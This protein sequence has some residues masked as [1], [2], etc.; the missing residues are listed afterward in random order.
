MAELLTVLVVD[1]EPDVCWALETLLRGHRFTV[2]TASSGADALRWLKVSEPICHLI[3]V[4]AK[5]SDI[6]GVDLAKRIRTETSC[7]APM[8]LVSGYFYKDDILVQDTLRTGLV[9][10]FVTKP[11]RHDEMLNAINAVLSTG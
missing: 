6:D 1:D 11:F 3:L 5:L 10:A 8:I 7:V 2:V 9:S 4:D